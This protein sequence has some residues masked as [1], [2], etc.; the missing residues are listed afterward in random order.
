V[1]IFGH[2]NPKTKE[3][4]VKVSK[5]KDKTIEQKSREMGQIEMFPS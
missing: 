2:Y 1:F 3:W 4:K 5:Q